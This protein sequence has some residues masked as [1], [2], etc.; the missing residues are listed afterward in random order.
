MKPRAVCACMCVWACVCVHECTH[1]LNV[2]YI[3]ELRSQFIF[4]GCVCF[5]ILLPN[6]VD[7]CSFVV[8]FERR[9][10]AFYCVPLFKINLIILGFLHFQVNCRFRLLGL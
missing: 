7:Y 8:S 9:H 3:T 5:F 1:V 10:V 4:H 2:D 6:Y